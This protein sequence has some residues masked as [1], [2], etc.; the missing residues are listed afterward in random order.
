MKGDTRRTFSLGMPRVFATSETP[1]SIIWLEVQSVSLF[2]SHAA[3][4]AWGS[5]MQCDSSGVV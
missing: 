1:Q 4:E 5:I 2:P 3:I